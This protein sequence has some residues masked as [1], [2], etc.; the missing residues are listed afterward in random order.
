M[1]SDTQ[2]VPVPKT[3]L[4]AGTNHERLAGTIPPRG[5]RDEIGKARGGRQDNRRTRIRRDRDSASGGRAAGLHDPLP[6]TARPNAAAS[7]GV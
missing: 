2:T 5:R 6:D 3:R 4:C 1:Q 7:T